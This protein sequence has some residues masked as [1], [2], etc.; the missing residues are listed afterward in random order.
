MTT[1]HVIQS[2]GPPCIISLISIFDPHPQPSPS[3]FWPGMAP[4]PCLSILP[5]LI[6]S[7]GL[8]EATAEAAPEAVYLSPEAA[9][10]H[11]EQLSG[12]AVYLWQLDYD[13]E[14]LAVEVQIAPRDNKHRAGKLNSSQKISCC[15]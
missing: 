14:V 11:S 7:C 6:I 1:K 12:G 9:P 8:R 13:N 5:L 15:R 2:D 3:P 10:V 4:S